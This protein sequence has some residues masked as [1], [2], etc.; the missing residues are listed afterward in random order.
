MRI[1]FAIAAVFTLASCGGGGSGSG[2]VSMLPPPPEMKPPRVQV[3][4][5][6]CNQLIY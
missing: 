3:P 4:Y 5:G 2:P 6:D 1:A